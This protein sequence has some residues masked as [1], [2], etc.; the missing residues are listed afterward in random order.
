V[1][2]WR[3]E[4]ET[5]D[6]RGAGVSVLLNL[7]DYATVVLTDHGLNTWSANQDI[8]QF[9]HRLK[10][11]G[12]EWQLTCQLWKIFKVLGAELHSGHEPMT[13]GITVHGEFAP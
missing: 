1:A 3:G 4:S 9:E 10:W 5:E 13:M 6:E 2:A 12:G 11:T 7:N 8:A